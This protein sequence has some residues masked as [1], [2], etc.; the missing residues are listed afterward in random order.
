MGCNL[1]L[2]FFFGGGKIS[3]F[4]FDDGEDKISLEKN[5]N[6]PSGPTLYGS[7]GFP[8]NFPLSN[9]LKQKCYQ[10]QNSTYIF[11]PRT[12]KVRNRF[13]RSFIKNGSPEPLIK[14]SPVYL[15]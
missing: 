2:I 1:T 14:M 9:F 13:L 6:K 7:N 3:N 10:E 12:F 5:F 8:S 11:I 15:V 4:I